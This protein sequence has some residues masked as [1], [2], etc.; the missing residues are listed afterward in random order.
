VLGPTDRSIRE[1]GETAAMVG[2]SVKHFLVKNHINEGGFAEWEADT[3]FAQKL[4]QMES[5]TITV[6]HLTAEATDTL[7][8][9]G[10]S[11]ASF[12]R[13]PAQS[14]M[15][16]G[17]VRSWLEAVWREFDRVRLGELIATAIN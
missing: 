15:L 17:Y 3:R 14:R 4:A 10:G 7:Q 13:D 11:F 5:V 8:R 12:S 9:A 16:R 1:I 2:G 6:P